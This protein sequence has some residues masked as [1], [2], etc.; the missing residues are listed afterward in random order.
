MKNNYKIKKQKESKINNNIFLNNNNKCINNKLKIAKN[1]MTEK[2]KNKKDCSE[3]NNNKDKT[4]KRI[5]QLMKYNIDEMNDLSYNLALNYDKRTFCQ[6]YISLIK[7]KHNLLFSFYNY[8]DY[9]S[10]IIKIDLFFIGFIMDYVVNAL[11]FND[12]AMHKIYED[13]GIFDWDTQIPISIYSFLISA[14]LNFPLSLLGL[15]NDNIIAFKQNL[16]NIG[17]Q[18][19]SKKL[20]FCLKLKLILYFFISFIFLLIFWYYI[21]MF[22]IIYKNTQYHLLKDTLISFIISMIEPFLIYLLPGFFRIP[23]LSNPKKKRKCLYN[24]SK[25]FQLI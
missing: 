24:F 16:K 5:K 9:N 2:N 12:E 19:R 8:D 1:I 7:V 13:K 15:S 10:R 22:G 21:S 6:Y 20:I 17:I 23:S 14:I 18:K 3:L 11:I 25:I 4:I